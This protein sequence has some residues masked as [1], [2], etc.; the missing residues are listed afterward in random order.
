MLRARMLSGL[1]VLAV[2]LGSLVASPAATQAGAL[3]ASGP[4]KVIGSAAVIDLSAFTPNGDTAFNDIA[5]SSPGNCT[6]VG[7]G[8]VGSTRHVLVVREVDHAWG[9]PV[10]VGS[11]IAVPN[12]YGETDPQVE[13]PVDQDT[14]SIAAN[15][16]NYAQGGQVWPV[17][18]QETSG[19][20]D[21]FVPVPVDALTGTSTTFT[22]YTCVSVG[23]C[24]MA[25]WGYEGAWDTGWSDGWL[26][27][28]IDGTWSANR[29]YSHD[30]QAIGLDCS[31]AGR[32]VAVM[33]SFCPF[34]GGVGCN[35]AA[36]N[37]VVELQNGSWGDPAKLSFPSD[38]WPSFMRALDCS[39]PGNCTMV[40]QVVS[41]TT[42]EFTPAVA[43]QVNGTWGEVQILGDATSSASGFLDHVSCTSAGHCRALGR[44][45]SYDAGAS[46]ALTTDSHGGSG[47]ATPTLLPFAGLENNGWFEVNAF[48]CVG[49]SDCMASGHFVDSSTQEGYTFTQAF[50]AGTWGNPA[51]Q[52]H[53][54]GADYSV[55]Q[56]SPKALVS[57]TTV[58]SCDMVVSV[59]SNSWQ[60]YLYG[61]IPDPPIKV[62]TSNAWPT[63]N[64]PV[65]FTANLASPATGGLVN[66]RRAADGK[67]LAHCMAATDGSCSA[68]VPHI[69]AGNFLV[70]A[71]IKRPGGGEYTASVEEAVSRAEVSVNTSASD[72]TREHWPTT[73]VRKARVVLQ[74]SSAAKACLAGIPVTIKVWTADW[75]KVQEFT[76]KA[77]AVGKLNVKTQHPLAIGDYFVTVSTPIWKTFCDS[78]WSRYDLSIT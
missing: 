41:Q 44:A 25:G 76:V 50:H 58:A 34:V 16:I 27:A 10:V 52:P 35:S 61:F 74:L 24:A 53:P 13:C 71:A 54:G 5:C 48:S 18:A 73:N 6:A 2:S 7:V 32:C 69:M 56:Y 19:S 67:V 63:Y 28:E 57:C 77:N 26:A 21:N 78:S 15:A 1:A 14:C 8:F 68:T 49:A 75:S 55:A 42:Y 9:Q 70:T 62:T 33:N 36:W 39:S 72:T 29:T 66:F 31:A 17:S 4:M 47:F 37:D 60:G 3:P 12:L 22:S 30:F 64:D 45:Y 43:E 65:T 38:G 51:V 59:R 46:V 11:S 23:N 40:G 20:W